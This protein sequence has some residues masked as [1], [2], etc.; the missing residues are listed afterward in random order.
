MDISA[1]RVL[2]LLDYDPLTGFFTRKTSRGGRPKGSLAGGKDRDGYVK[3]RLD[4]KGRSAHRLAWLLCRGL[5]VPDIMDHINGDKADNRIENL[6]AVTNA[7][8]MQSKFRP[9]VSSKLR[10]RGVDLHKGRF[11]AQIRVGKDKR[12]LGYFDSPENAH[13]AYLQAKQTAHPA[14]E[15]SKPY[16]P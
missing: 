11:R 9:Q 7:E 14:S 6:R 5:P 12:H 2:E 4:D 1:E 3:I 13:L 8:N 15:V 16:F 10:Y